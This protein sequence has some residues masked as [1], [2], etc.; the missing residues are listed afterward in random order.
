MLGVQAWFRGVLQGNSKY[1]DVGKKHEKRND[2]RNGMEGELD[3]IPAHS[4][5][6]N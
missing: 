3:K 6:P 4:F 2:K 1:V 5:F